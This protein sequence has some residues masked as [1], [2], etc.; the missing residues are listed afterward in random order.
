MSPSTDDRSKGQTVAVIG[1]G[2]VGLPTAATLAN[3]GHHV[4]L[5]EREPSKLS[6]LRS[7]RMPIVE[8]GLDDLV[9]GGVAAGNLSFTDSAIEAV[10][11]AAF[12]FLCVPTPQS[13][14]GSADLSYV[15][16]AAKEIASSLEPGASSSTSR[17][18]PSAPPTWSRR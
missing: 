15:E 18:C 8:A 17:R 3:F 14:D 7:G 6:T 12:V 4:V 11:G 13:A 10:A 5:A 2:Y 16:A 1:A 9:A